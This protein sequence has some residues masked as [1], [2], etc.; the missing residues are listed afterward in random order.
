M[1]ENTQTNNLEKMSKALELEDLTQRLADAEAA[2]KAISENQVDALVDPGEKT[3][4]M[5][6]N[7]QQA[8]LQS[9]NRYRRLVNRMSALVFELAPDGTILMANEAFVPL[10]GYS[11]K[12]IEGEKWGDVLIGD[13]QRSEVEN[14]FNCLM[15]EDV[16]DFELTILT[17][18]GSP[19]E[20][21]LTS[22]NYYDADG[23]LEK[24]V[25]FGINISKR[26][27]AE[28]TL[29]SNQERFRQVVESVRDYAIFTL[30][31]NGI[32]TSWNLGAENIF[33]QPAEEVIGEHFSRFY[34]PEEAEVGKPAKIMAAAARDGHYEEE[35]W[36]QRKDK[37]RFWANVVVTA[38]TDENGNITGYSKVVRDMTR[39]KFAEDELHRQSQFI[40]LVQ[41]VSVAANEASS[42]DPA[43]QYA[44]NRI[45]E[46]TLWNI[47][48]VYMLA[49]EGSGELVS[50]DIW[51]TG[52]DK[53]Y[54]EFKLKSGTY[55]Y[56]KGQGLPG[57]VYERGE[58]V[59]ISNLVD[60]RNF[61]RSELAKNSQIVMGFGFPILVGKQVVGVLEFF[62][63]KVNKPDEQILEMMKNIGTQLG[64]VVERK[65][66]DDALRTSEARFR[67]IF[68]DAAL[69]IELIS[70]DG[71]ILESNPAI[72][73]MLGYEADELRQVTSQ[74][75]HHPANSIA[76]IELFQELRSGKRDAYR[77]EQPYI[78]K[79]GR[80]GWGRSYVSLVRGSNGEPQFAIGMLE[81]IT[82]RKQME[83]ELAELQ[84]RL[85]EG[86]ESERLQL[87]REL[88]DGP[89]QD[90]YGISFL[91]KAFS[92]SLP[93][94]VD[95]QATDDLLNML[96]NVISTLRT[97]CGELR[98]PVL[99]PFGLAKAIRSHAENFQEAHLSSKVQLDLMTE[100]P[101]LSEQVQLVLFRI[102]QQILNNVAK[103]ANATNI[104]V[105]LSVNEEEAIL[106]VK[107]DGAGFIMP[108]RWIELARKGHLG[109]VSA[110]D[111]ARAIGGHLKV[112]SKPGEGT[113]VTVNVPYS[114]EQ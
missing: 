79:D 27:L 112:E 25:G 58:P 17:K 110:S 56:K 55:R 73:R 18:N 11:P 96:T 111:R 32:I 49:D 59:W 84:R 39:R 97:I 87:A 78:R 33:H 76:T 74:D 3:P 72:T 4:I 82:E 91:L 107:D 70:L 46:T 20:I 42:I 66:A 95:P 85:M 14:L 34:S 30:D 53:R 81:D 19:V 75:V 77:I 99:A 93:A 35:N 47:G 90:L 106:Q 54:D 63:D 98:P 31:P 28:E 62:S 38:L 29:I 12:E 37:T 2:L 15:T 65:Q 64:R 9:E 5:L 80:L 51:Y 102:Y 89:I 88:H 48:H 45:C 113:I 26:K 22:A 36:R 61:F 7:A 105:H 114:M 16:S 94:Q 21:E 10:T 100:G 86:R 101:N 60:Q 57:M 52:S 103:H 109:L 68:E 6:R 13:E 92:E 69:G 8:L 104:K 44:V 24:I 83:A 108:A 23:H 40:K 50:K 43:L 1:V 67:T 71:R 41:E